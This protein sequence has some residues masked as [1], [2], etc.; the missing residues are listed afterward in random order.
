MTAMMRNQAD[1]L[2]Q[3]CPMHVV[4]SIDGDIQSV[5]PTLQ[6]LRADRPMIGKRFLDVFET[7]RPRKA[8]SLGDL[9]KT[10]RGHI[11][12]SFRDPPHTSLKGMI[13][14][15]RG[16]GAIINLGFGLSIL[17]AVD[18]YN[19]TGIDF[20]PTDLA[21]E[22]LYL[23]EA[24]SAAMDATRKLNQRLKLA[25]A[26]LEEQA[27][28]DALTGLKNRR[29]VDTMLMSLLAAGRPFALM[30]MDL[31]FFKVV[32]DTHGHAA[33]DYVLK[34]VSAIMLRETR[35][36]DTCV[37][38]GG[39]EFVLI[40]DGLIDPRNLSAMAD[41]MIAAIKKPIPFNGKTCNI[42]ASAGSVIAS[43]L[44]DRTADE[45]MTHADMAL[46]AAK[47]AG[48]GRHI[49]FTPDLSA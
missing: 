18:S 34:H 40:L 39:D 31:D 4:V 33:G 21:V 41:R 37:R 3:L 44:D 27:S 10:P 16:R 17:D 48:R 26:A 12:L 43:S 29:S 25:M 23:V 7:T 8:G 49:Q 9:L 22:L 30:H 35:S 47:R 11:K 13:V 38:M 19:L 2:P 28:T 6:K 15:L 1:W 36:C 45:L 42:S 24:K 20:A 5:G 14:P 46:Y 32:N